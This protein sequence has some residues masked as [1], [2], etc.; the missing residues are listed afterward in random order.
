MSIRVVFSGNAIIFPNRLKSLLL[1]IFKLDK[2]MIR[3]VLAVANLA[4]WA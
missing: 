1:V 4:V 2:I 3:T